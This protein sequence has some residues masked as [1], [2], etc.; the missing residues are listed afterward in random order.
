MPLYPI[1]C[2]KCGAEDVAVATQSSPIGRAKAGQQ[3]DEQKCEECGGPCT[4]L[5][6]TNVADLTA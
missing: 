2:S 4:K 6:S 5:L 3:V 1:R